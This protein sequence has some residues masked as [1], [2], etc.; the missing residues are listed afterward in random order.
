MKKIT[1]LSL[2]LGIGG[3]EK[4]IKS[5]SKILEDDYEI[6]LIIT[7][8][9]NETPTFLFSNKI[10]IEYLIN[11]GPNREEIKRAIKRKK[12]FTLIKELLK[13]TKILTLK[14]LRTK[15]AIK[16]LETDY[17]ITTRTYETKLV[18]KLL[19]NKNIRKIA[20]DHNYPTK[21]Y[22]K[23]LI[24]STTNYD[25]LVVVNKEIEKIYKDEIGEKAICIS[26]FIDELSKE[27]TSLKEKNIISVGRL[28]K[29]KGF[30]D[31]I[32]I[33]KVLVEKDPEIKLTLIGDGPE[34]D[35]IKEKIKE[36]KLES[37]IKLTG[38]LNEREVNHEML[39]SS[40][41]VMTSY[42][43]S[44]GLVLVEAM[45]CGLP[46]VAF[47]TASGA[48]ELLNDGTGILI[49]NRN[50]EEMANKIIELL[51]SKKIIKEYSEKSLSK[52]KNYIAKSIKPEWLNLLESIKD[53]STKKVLFISSTGGHLN[54]LLML[55]PMFKKYNYKLI[56]EKTPTNKNLQNKYG[57]KNVK[58]LIYG[59]RKHFITYPFK[60]AINSIKSLYYFIKFKPKFIVSTGAHTA[61]PMCLIAHLFKA[62]IIYI[63]TF[64][65]SETKSVTGSIVYKFADLFIVQW[66]D[67]LKLYEKATY[68]GWIYW[69]L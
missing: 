53:R 9:L 6:S 29:E 5:L 18:N 35:K 58:F 41:Y 56:T 54:E 16:N 66:E 3:I 22:K 2:H 23:E 33:M 15:K 19:K 67:M 14:K 21:K 32:D 31:L 59:T 20:T 11:G 46:I 69:Y 68:G 65:N 60:L 7:Y 8:K 45:N 55:S 4:Y 48:R 30:L 36:Y 26:N 57:R 43:E 44:F 12:F 24:K 25:K 64:A 28:S 62:K 37:N 38:F 52:V 63:E 34:S 10:K 47:D 61:G 1:I 39:N 42:T 50:K 51:N 17:L 27:T 13:A 40:L 49:K